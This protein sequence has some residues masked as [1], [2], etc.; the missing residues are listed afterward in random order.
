MNL[1]VPKY[2]KSLK[3]HDILSIIYWPIHEQSANNASSVQA[4]SMDFTD[5]AHG[6]L[7]CNPR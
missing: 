2:H 4:K 5:R 1:K 3:N 6:N 7:F